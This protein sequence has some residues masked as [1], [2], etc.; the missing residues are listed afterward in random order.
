MGK[1][2]DTFTDFDKQL[3]AGM[4]EVVAHINGAPNPT[5]A[6]TSKFRLFSRVAL[7]F[8]S[9]GDCDWCQLQVLIGCMISWGTLSRRYSSRCAGSGVMPLRMR[10]TLPLSVGKTIVAT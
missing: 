9:L 6:P 10:S 1:K 5:F 2:T 8:Q 3:I 4:E 7:I